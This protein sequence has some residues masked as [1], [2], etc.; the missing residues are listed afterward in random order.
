MAALGTARAGAV[1]CLALMPAPALLVLAAGIGS[2]FGGLKQMD[3]IGP[4]GEI[5]IDYSIFDALRAGFGRIVLIVKP[6]LEEP[7]REH[8]RGVFG[9]DFAPEFV[10]QELSMVPPGYSVP[11]GREK[12]WGTAHAVWCARS[13]LGESFGVVNADDF[14]GA[15]AYRV[16]FGRLSQLPTGEC[17]LVGFPLLP[18]LSVHGTVSRG[19]CDVGPDGYLRSVVEHLKVAL[20]DGKALSMSADGAS[21]DLPTDS[22]ASMNMWGF[23]PSIFPLLGEGLRR[24]LDGRGTEPKS[25]M[26]LPSFVDELARAGKTKCSVLRTTSRWFGMTYKE[27]KEKVAG[28]I[29]DLISSGEYPE[30]LVP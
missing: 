25:E 24:F 23:D 21:R 22:L 18:T 12:P 13:A 20:G 3:P 9:R 17:C 30:R 8:F 16:L 10:V 2:R 5:I 15:D 27:D 26:L 14:Y 4:N 19:I 29:R 28:E 1:A 6:E 11:E 7:M